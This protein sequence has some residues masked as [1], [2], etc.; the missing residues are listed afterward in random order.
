MTDSDRV[1]DS[2]PEKAFLDANVIR[3]QL[4]NDILLTLAEG[5]VHNPRWSQTVIDEMR[6][7]RP[8]GVSEQKID[9]RINAMDTYF[10]RAMV[11]GYEH[12]IPLMSADEK[13]KH[14]L[15]AAVHGECDVLVTDNLKDFSPPSTGPHAMR[16][17]SAS[18]F[19]VR[20]LEEQP[21]RVVPALQA[22]VDGNRLEPRTMRALLDQMAAQ[23]ELR[24]FAQALNNRV[25]PEDRGTHEA[26]TKDSTVRRMDPHASAAFDG[27]APADG[28]AAPG[29]PAAQKAERTASSGQAH[30]NEPER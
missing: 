4:T 7:N 9:R 26:L 25:E 16:V 18:Q 5:D 28:A 22:M 1:F 21:Q 10:T 11:V 12:L 19:L 30:S 13:D 3:G 24:A 27:I 2:E 15:A 8:A 20:K 6:R 23:P 29:P 14:V 17:E